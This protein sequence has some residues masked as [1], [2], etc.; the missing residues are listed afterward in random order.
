M[1]FSVL[2]LGAS[3]LAAFIVPII[4]ERVLQARAR[5]VQNDLRVFSA[6]FQAYAAE[7]GDWPPGD[8]APGAVPPGMLKYLQNT[9]W[10]RRTPIGGNY[11]WDPESLH[12][13]SRVRAAIVIA[14]TRGNLVTSDRI[15]LQEID[16]GF[17]DANLTTGNFFLGYRNWP[18]FVL[19]R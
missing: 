9:H 4:K 7:H 19:E 13:G 14:G 15:Q 8:G 12:Q 1:A 17:D 18:L 6:A 16:R 2:V 11:A 10:Q 3:I 5:A